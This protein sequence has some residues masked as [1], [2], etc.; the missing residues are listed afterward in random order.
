MFIK[1]SSIKCQGAN[2]YVYKAQ[3][4]TLDPKKFRQFEGI[5]QKIYITLKQNT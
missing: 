4:S 1:I 5:T 3:Y 2:S